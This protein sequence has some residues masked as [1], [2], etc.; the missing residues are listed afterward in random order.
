MNNIRYGDFD[1]HYGLVQ[2]YSTDF[3]QHFTVTDTL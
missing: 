1:M 3:K 2:I